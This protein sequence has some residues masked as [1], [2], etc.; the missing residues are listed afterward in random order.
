MF[1]W[2]R[3][4]TFPFWWGPYCSSSSFHTDI[5]SNS[6]WKPCCESTRPSLWGPSCVIFDI[7]S[8]EKLNSNASSLSQWC[9]SL[10]CTH[11]VAESVILK[12]CTKLWNTIELK[13]QSPCKENMG[14]LKGVV[15]NGTV[16]R[17]W[18]KK[19]RSCVWNNLQ[20]N[21]SIIVIS[22][23]FGKVDLKLRTDIFFSL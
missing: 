19:T 5:L 13:N 17:S 14:K 23:T 20:K 1:H 8:L 12:G 4:Q 7:I 10:E 3:M 9:I 15:L 6:F 21:D 2:A 22:Q 11:A 18:S 16:I